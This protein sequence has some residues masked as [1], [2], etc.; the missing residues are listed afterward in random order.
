MTRD[1]TGLDDSAVAAQF[2]GVLGELNTD[3]EVLLLSKLDGRLTQDLPTYPLF[4]SPVS[5]VQQADIANVSESP[6][7]AG[8]FWDAEDWVIELRQPTGS[9][10][11][12]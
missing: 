10:A 7:S 2:E 11:A 1:V 3:T 8:P 4:Q 9:P 6:T 12:A 5:L